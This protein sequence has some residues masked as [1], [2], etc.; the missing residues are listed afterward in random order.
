MITWQRESFTA[1]TEEVVALGTAQWDEI[2]YSPLLQEELAPDIIALHALEA[3]GSL[4]LVT[5]REDDHLAGYILLVSSAML[6][7]KDKLYAMEVSMYVD[8]D[9][10]RKGVAR[11]LMQYCEQVCREAGIHYLTFSVTPALDYSPLLKSEGYTTTEIMHTK[12][13]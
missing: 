11:G 6:N 1:V 9:Y 2:R 4:L 5:A 7:H 10:R 13:L 12:R 3:A 8:E